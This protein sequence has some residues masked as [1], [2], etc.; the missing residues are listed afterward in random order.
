MILT[1]SQIVEA[2]NKGDIGIDPFDE[3]QVQPA[4]YDLRV[5]P[6]GITTST[7]KIVNLE[8][9]AY[10]SIQPGDFALVTTYEEVML[11]QQYVGRI[12]LRSGYARQGLI[13]TTGPQID[14]GYHGRLII[15]LTN[16]SPK[17][18]S[19]PYKDH[20]LSVEFHRLEQPATT[21]YNGPY[22]GKTSLG[23]DDIKSVTEAE[24][25]ALSEM[26]TTLRSLTQNVAAM[27]KEMRMLEIIL[28]AVMLVGITIIGIIVGMKH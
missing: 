4:T 28:P 13:A 2:R 16:L 7:K 25:M 18:I 1:D 14:P 12:G 20:F 21:T 23:A 9:A 8:T 15:G 17:A 22:Q 5:G 24:G 11:G 6:Q 26:L 3:K 19:L 27:A 10:V